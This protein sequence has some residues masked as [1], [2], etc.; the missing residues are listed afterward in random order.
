MDTKTNHHQN[1]NK[2]KIIKRHGLSEFVRGF[3]SLSSH[4]INEFRKS[5]NP[6]KWQPLFYEHIIR[7]EQELN[8]IRK[9]IFDNPLNWKLDVNFK[10]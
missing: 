7:D 6:E 5:K 1:E 4:R 8:R 10:S 2:T 3:K 9:Y